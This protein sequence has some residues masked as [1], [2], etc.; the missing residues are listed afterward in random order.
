MEQIF[1]LVLVAV[2]GLVRWYLQAAENKKDAETPERPHSPATE[3][4]SAPAQSEEERIRK[5][6]EALGVPASASPPPK[7][8]ARQIT[9]K[10][11][12]APRT[13]LPVDPFPTPRTRGLPPFMEAPPPFVA[14]APE[15]FPDAPP[16]SPVP[17]TTSLERAS[18][19]VKRERVPAKFEVRDIDQGTI[20]D[21]SQPASTQ[22]EGALGQGRVPWRA[23]I[24]ARLATP[25]GMREAIVLTEDSWSAA[26]PATIRLRDRRLSVAQSWR[27][28][29][30]RKVGLLSTRITAD[31]K[32][33]FIRTAEVPER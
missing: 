14:S 33:A 19:A 15:A 31:G 18:S 21:F 8:P 29:L 32:C 25:E 27:C 20:D 5:F 3:K 16:P 10:P 9:P 24:S 12:R 11:R 13:I 2:V 30:G 22:A 7:T 6:F 4:S 17:A 1:F 23:G 26:K 28:K